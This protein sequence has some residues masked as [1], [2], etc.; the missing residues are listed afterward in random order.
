M[1]KL[2]IVLTLSMG[3][4]FS[5]NAAEKPFQAFILSDFSKG[6]NSHVSDSNSPN[7]SADRYENF[8]VNEKYAALCKRNSLISV[9]DMGTSAI[10]GLHRYYKNDGTAYTVAATGTT[11][12]IDNDGTAQ[13]IDAGLSDGKRWQFITYNDLCIGGN[14]SDRPIKY[15]GH[16]QVTA[17]TDGSRTSTELCAE[18]GAPFAELNTGANLTAAKW[19]VYKVMFVVSG[20][21]YYSQAKSNPLLTGAAVRDIYLTDIPIGP[22]GTTSRQIYRISGA[23][24][25]AA[26]EAE[27]SYYLVTTIEDNTTSVYADTMTDATLTGQTAWDTTGKYDCSPPTG[28]LWYNHNEYTFVAGNVT[29][30]SYLYFSDIYNPDFFYP[31]HFERIQKDDGDKITFIKTFRGLLTIGKTNSISKYYT[32][33]TPSTDWYVSGVYS[34]IGCPAPY[35]V[36]VSPLG[37][38]YRGRDGLYLFDGMS[39]RLV[40]DSVTQ[41]VRDISQADIENAVGVFY[42]NTYKFAYTSDISDAA[43]N[44]RVLNYNIV[45]DAYTLDTMNIGAFTVLNSGDDTGVLYSGSSTT[46]GYIVSHAGGTETLARRYKSNLDAG[47][48]DD[49]ASF[50]EELNPVLELSW[51]CTIGGW[52]TELQTKN[53][54]INDIGD[55]ATYLPNSVIGRPDTGGTWTSPVY[56]VNSLSLDR[57]Y[58]NED[59]NGGDIEWQIRTGDT[60]TPDGTWSSWTATEYTNPNGSDISSESGSSYLQLKAT[61]ST[62]DVDFTPQLYLSDGYLFRIIYNKVG[63]DYETSVLGVWESKWHDFKIPGYKKWIKRIQV[64]YRATGGELVLN[65]KNDEGDVDRDITIDLSVEPDD[66][67]T[68]D[69]TG[70]GTYKVYT[71]L[72]PINS[73]DVPSLIGQYWRF[74]LTQNST[75]DLEIQKVEVLFEVQPLY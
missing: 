38:F 37:L 28:N 59:L 2:L 24:S 7:E 63:S 5:S 71:Y 64:V 26:A 54:S 74:K 25:Q 10:T 29:Y 53:A 68:D 61:F 75:D 4:V 6:L 34:K 69:Y 30:P 9:I 62:T 48:F 21:T 33:G 47:T 35:S 17:N 32:E 42:D 1:K 66:S 19:Y 40:S 60:E 44:N 46:D 50:G 55:I 22:T 20:V 65:L 49:T 70:F 52:L 39:S 12:K 8:R 51:D 16:T 27:T 13:T 56:T 3:V 41:E 31:T 18:L 36:A 23:A 58:W 14:N 45:R 15:D 67:S 72:P 43:Y 57:L 11:L 73:E